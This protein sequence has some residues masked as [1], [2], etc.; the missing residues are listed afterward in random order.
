MNCNKFKVVGN[1]LKV[2]FVCLVTQFLILPAKILAG[3]A[4]SISTPVADPK[5]FN[6]DAMFSSIRNYFFGFII[7][8]CV[9]I[10]LWGAFDLATSGGDETKVKDAKNRILYAVVGLIVAAM[11]SV[12]ISLVRVMVGV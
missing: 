6:L 12:I 9:F 3:P 10:I 8:A 2:I 1:C 4:D 11:S 5:N 7:V